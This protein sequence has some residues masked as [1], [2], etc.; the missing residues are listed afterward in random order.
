MC[1][2]C[3]DLELVTIRLLDEHGAMVGYLCD[4]CLTGGAARIRERQQRMA[5][6]HRQCAIRC[7]AD[8]VGPIE[9]PSIELYRTMLSNPIQLPAALT[10]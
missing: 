2:C 4:A 6:H 10:H 5:I 8:A 3:F 7:E 1:Q 9:M